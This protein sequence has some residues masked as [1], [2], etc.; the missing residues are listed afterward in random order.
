MGVGSTVIP[1]LPICNQGGVDTPYFNV[2][3]LIVGVFFYLPYVKKVLEV[4]CVCSGLELGT[5][6]DLWSFPE[7]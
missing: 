6:I 2:L 3:Q 4:V 1:A 5:P 7:R